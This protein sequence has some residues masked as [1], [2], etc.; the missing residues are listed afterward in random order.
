[1]KNNETL[2]NWI[3]DPQ[4]VNDVS[5]VSVL[6]NEHSINNYDRAQK[7][8]Y[9]EM[10]KEEDNNAKDTM[11]PQR[12][13]TLANRIWRAVRLPHAIA[14]KS[15][16]IDFFDRYIN[17]ALRNRNGDTISIL[18]IGTFSGT[19][20]TDLIL[21]HVGKVKYLGVDIALTPLIK[22]NKK[23]DALDATDFHLVCDTI[24]S[25]NFKESTFDLIIG[26]GVLHHFDR[27]QKPVLAQQIYR[28][29]KPGGKA[30]FVEPLNTNPFL[31]AARSL[32]KVA[33]PNLIWEHP[34]S[35]NELQEFCDKFDFSNLEFRDGFRLL[36]LPL[37]P[38][39]KPY[40]VFSNF[41]AN[42]DKIISKWKVFRPLFTKSFMVFERS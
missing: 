2:N 4:L 37:A 14:G 35:K 26:R 9:E 22:L 19:P 12:N 33:R 5:G 42:F 38:L 11:I 34:F 30:I 31:I 1:M 17:S 16:Q 21:K 6:L 13:E 29:L 39:G 23:F 25:D 40:Q 32:T 10:N 20:A 15:S 28:L 7:N 27:E 8:F 24:L 36:A 3:K 18:E 41:F